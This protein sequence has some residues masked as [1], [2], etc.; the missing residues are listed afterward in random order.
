MLPNEGLPSLCESVMST[1]ARE[2]EA[3][4][5]GEGEGD[6]CVGTIALCRREIVVMV[7]KS[8]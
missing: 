1:G 7:H 6:G 4:G 8:E 3:E 5:E 2:A